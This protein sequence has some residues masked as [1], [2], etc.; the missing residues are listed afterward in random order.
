MYKYIYIYTYVCIDVHIHTLALGPHSD[1]YRMY[2]PWGVL[3]IGH[4][5]TIAPTGQINAVVESMGQLNADN[6]TTEKGWPG[7]AGLTGRSWPPW[8]AKRWWPSP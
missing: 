4:P 2:V 6:A 3:L 7:K 1:H 5:R 8:P